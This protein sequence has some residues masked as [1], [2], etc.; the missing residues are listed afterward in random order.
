MLQHQYS[1]SAWTGKQPGCYEPDLSNLPKLPLTPPWLKELSVGLNCLYVLVIIM[2]TLSIIA[3][4]ILL[5]SSGFYVDRILINSMMKPLVIAWLIN[6]IL[7][8][9]TVFLF[10]TQKKHREHC[11]MKYDDLAHNFTQSM[12]I[13][14]W[15]YN[16]MSIPTTTMGFMELTPSVWKQRGMADKFGRTFFDWNHIKL[17]VYD[18]STTRFKK[19]LKICRKA[20]FIIFP[21]LGWSYIMQMIHEDVFL[22][23]YILL[24]VLQTLLLFSGRFIYAREKQVK[25]YEYNRHTGQ[26]SKF[27]PSGNQLWSYPFSE[28]NMYVRYQPGSGQ[29][30]RSPSYIPY[31]IHRYSPHWKVEDIISFNPPWT[32]HSDRQ[33]TKELMDTLIAFMNVTLPLPQCLALQ[34]CR[35]LDSTTQRLESTEAGNRIDFLSMSDKEY[36]DMLFQIWKAR[37][38]A[39]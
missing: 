29:A 13:Y 38:S 36:K 26:V 3:T 25:L 2:V 27:D 18:Y 9:I 32:T 30:D 28:F 5:F 10:R 20:N 24:L 8:V 16:G 31:M 35:H 37:Q 12:L 7:I 23:P 21:L 34:A 19:W 39:Y 11:E 1:E 4:L 15:V 6:L 22:P 33:S 17:T 14:K